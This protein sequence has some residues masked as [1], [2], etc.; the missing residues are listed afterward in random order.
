MSRHTKIIAEIGVNHNGQIDLA[1]KMVD[2]IARCGADTAKFQTTVPEK[3]VSKFAGKAEYQK[4][5]T[6]SDESQLEMIRKITLPHDTSKCPVCGSN[7]T[8]T[9]LID[10]EQAECEGTGL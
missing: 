8:I 10:Y 9:E 6:G 3:L 5:T 2:E 7:P 4:E 1:K